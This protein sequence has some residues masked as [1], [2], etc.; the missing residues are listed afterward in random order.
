MICLADIIWTVNPRVWHQALSGRSAFLYSIALSTG[1]GYVLAFS[2]IDNF[3]LN[4]ASF[5]VWFR[6]ALSI[7]S[8]AVLF[9]L[10]SIELIPGCSLALPSPRIIII[11]TIS[12]EP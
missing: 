1:N 11:K 8:I 3:H 12:L 7:D 6:I 2:I 5:G 4:A 10:L 9:L